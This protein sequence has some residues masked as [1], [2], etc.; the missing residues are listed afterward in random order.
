[1]DSLRNNWET[2][3]RH[4]LSVPR[5][6]EIRY[7]SLCPAIA[8]LDHPENLPASRVDWRRKP[9]CSAWKRRTA[10]YSARPIEPG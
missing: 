4:E 2:L 8:S 7:Q 6:E 5:M 9:I 10:S 1:M 3:G